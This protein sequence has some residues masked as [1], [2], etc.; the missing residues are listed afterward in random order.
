M[1]FVSRRPKVIL[2]INKAL[3]FG[4]NNALNDLLRLGRSHQITDWAKAWVI[5]L[6]CTKLKDHGYAT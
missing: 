2:C 1:S 6:A 3:G 5:S 4:I